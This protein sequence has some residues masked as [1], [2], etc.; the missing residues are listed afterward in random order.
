MTIV[1][2]TLIESRIFQQQ[3]TNK[4]QCNDPKIKVDDFVY[5]STKI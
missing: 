3:Y 4:K 5:L 1:H 2:D